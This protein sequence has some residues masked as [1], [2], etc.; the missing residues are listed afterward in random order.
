[1]LS[2]TIAVRPFLNP[3]P[4]TVHVCTPLETA[5][6]TFKGLALRHLLVVNDCGD[7]AGIV[8]RHDL[9]LSHVLV[10]HKRVDGV[11]GLGA[12]EAV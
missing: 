8:T 2:S 6:A 9:I 10:C 12:S 11:A 1:M 3:A 7:A 5:Y 4:A